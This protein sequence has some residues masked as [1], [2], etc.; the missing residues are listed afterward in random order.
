MSAVNLPR[1][2]SVKLFS[3]NNVNTWFIIRPTISHYFRVFLISVYLALVSNFSLFF[4]WLTFA[5][6]GVIRDEHTKDVLEPYNFIKSI[7][8]PKIREKSKS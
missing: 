7:C 2:L 8:Q 1:V 4:F 6:N 5:F 3:S